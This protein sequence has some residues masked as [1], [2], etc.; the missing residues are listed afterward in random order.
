MVRLLKHPIRWMGADDAQ[1]EIILRTKLSLD[2]RRKPAMFNNSNGKNHSIGFQFAM[3]AIIGLFI[4]FGVFTIPDVLLNYTINFAV[5]MVMLSVMLISEFTSVL[6]D[7]RDNH[8]LLVRP[9]N[10]RTLLLSRLLHIQFYVGLM[11]LALSAFTVI[12]T[13]IKLG[14]VSSLLYL[15]SVFA[16]VWIVIIATTF[17][18][19]L[20]SRLVNDTKF[21]DII[22]Y[23]QIVLAIIIMGGYQLLP[24]LMESDAVQEYSMSVHAYTFFIPPVWLAAVL[25][26]SAAG[27]S[28][29]QVVYLAITGVVFLLAGGYLL[30]R[31]LSKGFIT[32]L[33][34]ASG[35]SVSVHKESKGENVTMVGRKS[36]WLNFI[37][38][39]EIE[40]QGRNLVNAITGRDRKFKQAVYPS[41][42]MMLVMAFAFLRPDFNDLGAFVESLQDSR[43][44][45]FFI[46][47][48]FFAAVPVTNM[49]YTDTPEAGWIYK[50]LPLTLPGHILT[51]AIKGVLVKYFIPTYAILIV[52]VLLIWG[53]QALPSMIL[54][55]LLTISSTILTTHIQKPGLP[56]TQ[57]REM[58]QKGMNFI[59]V[60]LAFL[61]MGAIIAAVYFISMLP[62]WVVTLVCFGVVFFNVYCFR[63]LRAGVLV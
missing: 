48:G 27:T 60:M 15:L 23:V 58:Q 8:I 5:I 10:E 21:K 45:L 13:M 19:L 3:Y 29:L 12:F 22:S 28:D 39:S 26:L 44:Y 61:I 56:F 37:Y 20:L 47:F 34:T 6:F 18:Y 14:I 62:I 40:K 41:I 59:K 53:I 35:A 51:G 43:K 11:G 31:F 7:E 25:K 63:L 46:F 54:G 24:R 38:I 49:T 2:F 9:V 55:C 17:F 57:P 32:T 16:C 36:S 50:A 30:I 1:L 33:T 52:A 4:G 42:G